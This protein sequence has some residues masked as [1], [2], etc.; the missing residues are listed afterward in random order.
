MSRP[1]AAS[2][3]AIFAVVFIDLLG[4]GIVLPLLA[5]YGERF[6]AD[7]WLGPLV[8]SFSAMQF[9]FAPLWGRLS[10]RIGRRPV[11]LVGL[12]GSAACYAL[13]GVATGMEP[14][15]T[16]LGLSPLAWL[17]VSRIGAG[18]AG[19][20]IPTAQ[21]YIADVTGPAERTKG[22]AL[23]GIAFGTGFTFGPIL[24][25]A[26]VS[27]DPSAPPSPYPGYLAAGLSA[28]AFVAALAVLKEPE[29]HAA[30]AA[31]R[32]AGRWRLLRDSVRLAVVGEI[33][34]T[35]A[36]FAMFESTLALLSARFGY[37]DRDNFYLFAFVGAT[38]IVAQGVLVRRIA[39]ARLRQLVPAGLAILAVGLSSLGLLAA[40]WVSAPAALY[41]A[42]AACV[43]GVSFVSPSLQSLL[44]LTTPGDRQGAML[45]LGQSAA[46]LARIAGPVAGIWL[47]QR[48]APL[49]YAAAAGVIAV[50]LAAMIP[51]LA[52]IRN[53]AAHPEPPATT[54]APPVRA[55]A[56]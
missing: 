47:F 13:F 34:L 45:G 2:L 37:S 49:A 25:A 17:F 18:I 8:A 4:F 26:F 48:S 33:F 41:A 30:R 35:T 29:R 22:M 38:L 40:G 46:A 32:P 23:I 19:A 21:A 43:V 28:A 11:L 3:A 15:A 24:G 55:A 50:S 36:A 54:I 56:E 10:D 6:E 31:A 16:L 42:L 27:D 12:A 1:R 44:S 51:V 14:D 53:R 39:P 7:A 9:L 52:T 5:R 20:T